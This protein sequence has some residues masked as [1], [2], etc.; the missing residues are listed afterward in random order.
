M[1]GTLVTT[2]S[3]PMSS[4]ATMRAGSSTVHTFSCNPAAW[5]NSTS[6]GMTVASKA[7][8]ATCPAAA[9]GHVALNA[10][11]AT[12][13]PELVEFAHAAGLQLNVWTVD[14]PARIVALDDMGVDG[15]VTNVP[16]IAA[17]ALGR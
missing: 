6:S 5:A 10:F 14:D 11:D 2:P 3:T 12:V 1:S 13:I 15:V 17:A 9:A 4:S 16:D 7:F 8:S